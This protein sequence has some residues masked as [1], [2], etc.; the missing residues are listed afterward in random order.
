MLQFH[1]CSNYKAWF[2]LSPLS[3]NETPPMFVSVNIAL[4]KIC[5]TKR[6][7]YLYSYLEGKVVYICESCQPWKDETDTQQEHILHSADL[8]Y[9]CLYSIAYSQH[10]LLTTR[11]FYGVSACAK[12][13]STKVKF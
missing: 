5:V 12:V 8:Q 10:N 2:K 6:K 4:A 3:G 7:S 13:A 1:F 11:H 9:S